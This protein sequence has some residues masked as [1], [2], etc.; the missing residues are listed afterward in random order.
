[1]KRK[2]IKLDIYF[3]DTWHMQQGAY[4]QKIIGSLAQ[5]TKVGNRGFIAKGRSQ[6]KEIAQIIRKYL[7]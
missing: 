2:K 1:M 3:Q 5:R 6:M 4:C 7:D